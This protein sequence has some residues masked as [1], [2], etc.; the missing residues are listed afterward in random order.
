MHSQCLGQGGNMATY[1]K[2]KYSVAE[3]GNLSIGQSGFKEL[4]AAGNTGNGNFCAFLITG[5]EESDHAVVAATCHIGDDMTACK[6]R[7][8]Q[9]VYGAFNKITVT[10]PADADVHVLCYYG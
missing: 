7:V 8:G 5:E 2:H 10:S 9:L 3:S 4:V 1:G 6:F